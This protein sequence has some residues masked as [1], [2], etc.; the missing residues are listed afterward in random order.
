MMTTSNS[1]LVINDKTFI[2]EWK[3]SVHEEAQIH[4]VIDELN[5]SE[6]NLDKLK[7][8]LIGDLGTGKTT[9]TRTW[10]HQ[11]GVRGNI[12]SPTFNLV[13]HYSIDTLPIIHADLYRLG[14]EQELDELNI[15]EDLNEPGL[16]LIEWGEKFPSLVA[17]AN[18]LLI[19]E[20]IVSDNKNCAER[21]FSF[22]RSKQTPLATLTI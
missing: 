16:V 6:T 5:I 4:E 7:L 17:Q 1:S 22:Y 2:L 8:L 10:L 14:N 11:L 13:N 18:A 12:N 21:K 19:I 20:V 15:I 9:L 3:K